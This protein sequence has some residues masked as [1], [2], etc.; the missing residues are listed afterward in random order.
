MGRQAFHGVQ[1]NLQTGKSYGD[2]CERKVTSHVKSQGCYQRLYQC[3]CHSITHAQHIPKPPS[4]RHRN[5][6][7]RNEHASS[8]RSLQL[9]LDRLIGI[10]LVPVCGFILT[11]WIP[12]PIRGA[13]Y[14]WSFRLSYP[15]DDPGLRFVTRGMYLGV[16][17]VDLWFLVCAYLR[18][19]VCCF[20]R[21]V[22]W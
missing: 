10:Y 22:W 3:F 4:N 5:L 2:F 8:H 13:V 21:R 20:I 15:C 12:R 14:E 1:A 16:W 9:Q 19:G 18:L 6:E 17:A 11:E 7:I